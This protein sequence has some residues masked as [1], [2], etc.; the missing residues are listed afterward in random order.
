M[1]LRSRE[2]GH[3]QVALVRPVWTADICET[4]A[5]MGMQKV[6]KI[7]HTERHGKHVIRT[8]YNMDDKRKSEGGNQGPNGRMSEYDVGNVEPTVV[9]VLGAH[10]RQEW[11]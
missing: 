8:P 3:E 2:S 5:E 7:G 4:E 10:S 1:F 9:P 11:E 6:I